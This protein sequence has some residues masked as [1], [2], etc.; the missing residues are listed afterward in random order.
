M[1]RISVTQCFLMC[2]ALTF[3]SNVNRPIFVAGSVQ[4]SVMFETLTVARTHLYTKPM[5]VECSVTKG[6]P[7]HTIKS[8]TK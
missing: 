8:V 3:I 5:F 4:S 1:Q 6:S 2:S 7:G